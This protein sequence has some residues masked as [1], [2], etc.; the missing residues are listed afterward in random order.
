VAN[1]GIIFKVNEVNYR[2][3]NNLSP[4]NFW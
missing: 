4:P 2:K 3:Q 1:D